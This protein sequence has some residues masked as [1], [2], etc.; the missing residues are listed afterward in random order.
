MIEVKDL[1]E[2][3]DGGATLTVDMSPDT[4]RFLVEIGLQVI[5]ARAID[6]E[7]EDWELKVDE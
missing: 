4:T 3:E 5:L 7:N 6:L 2:H 1:V